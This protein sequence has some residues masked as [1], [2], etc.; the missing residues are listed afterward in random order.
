MK[1]Q[2]TDEDYIAM[3]MDDVKFQK[4]QL[5][6]KSEQLEN[7]KKDLEKCHELLNEEQKKYRDLLFE[8]N[9]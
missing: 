3:N 7:T 4:E 1:D 2:I 6:D 5:K 9:E 8:S